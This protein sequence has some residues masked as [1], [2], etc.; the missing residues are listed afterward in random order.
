[1]A[2]ASVVVALPVAGLGLLLASPGDLG[3]VRWAGV[4]LAWWGTTGALAVQALAL[5]I[6]GH[7]DRSSRDW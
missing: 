1:V 6:G 3:T 7:A 5:L 4:G 2:L